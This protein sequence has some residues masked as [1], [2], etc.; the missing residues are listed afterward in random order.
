MSS[1]KLTTFDN[2]PLWQSA[3]IIGG[4]NLLGLALSVLTTS[5]YHV[6]LLGT[7]AFALS[8][9]PQLLDPSSNGRIKLSATFVAVWATKLASFLFYRVIKNKHDARL[10]GTLS[11]VSGCMGFWIIS[12]LWGVLCALPHYIGATST[13]DGSHSA[14]SLGSAMY[15]VGLVVE[16]LADYQKWQFKSKNPGKFCDVGLWSI[17]QHPNWFG[18]LLLWGGIFVMNVPAMIEPVPEGASQVTQIL[19]YKRVFISA[20]SPLFMTW[21]FRGEADG[22]IT[23]AVELSKKRYGDDPNFKKYIETV[24]LIVP[25]IF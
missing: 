21:L 14:V 6:D 10:D 20:L 13:A 2:G 4:A 18:N 5:H 23:N 15:V 24:P 3:S 22:T 8:V 25:K 9:I 1:L 12:A 7:G 11:T 19:S 16:T 17:S